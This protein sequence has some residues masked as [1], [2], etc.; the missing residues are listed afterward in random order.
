[1]SRAYQCVFA[2]EFNASDMA[3]GEQRD[4]PSFSSV[5]TPGGL[6][7]TNLFCAGALIERRGRVG[8][9]MHARL[10][11]PT[12]AFA[13]TVDHT[14]RVAAAILESMDVPC[15]ATVVGEPVLTGGGREGTCS[16][17][18]EEIREVAR[19]VR[20][21]WVLRTADL[22]LLRIEEMC[23][24]LQSG[25]TDARMEALISHYRLDMPRLRDIALMVK[26]AIRG[27][28]CVT[29]ANPLEKDPLSL[30]L[31]IIRE[32][33]GKSGITLEEITKQAARQ[34]VNAREVGNAVE[35]LIRDD[36]CYQPARGVL[37]IL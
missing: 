28:G 9:P 1:M 3:C 2:G 36:E 24:S 25:R 6:V 33:G 12:G 13:L 17:R 32:H 26:E 18:V 23:A 14:N 20:D 30:V 11:D 7:C 37:K 5:L 16:I 15:F 8:E 31:A 27:T 29:P 19:D 21:A 22:T 35:A 34:G 4:I 10:A